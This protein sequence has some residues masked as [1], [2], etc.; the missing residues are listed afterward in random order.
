MKLVTYNTRFGLGKDHR[1]NLPRIVDAVRGADVIALQ[2]IRRNWP[3]NYEDQPGEIGALLPEYYWIYGPTFDVDASQKTNDGNVENRRRQ[4]GTMLL[5]KTPIIS[6]RLHV[7]P[8]LAAVN[9]FNMDLGAVEGVI[10]TPAGPVR[11]YSIH[12][13]ALGSRERVMQ[14][15]HFLEIHR[16]AW[17]EGGAWTGPEN[18][19]EADWSGGEPMPPMS[20][21]AVVMG[22]FNSEKDTPEYELMAGKKDTQLGNIA[23]IDSFVDSWEAAGNG[24]KEL[25]TWVHDS[26]ASGRGKARLDYCF[27]SPSLAGKV[28]NAWLDNEAPGSDHQ[29][30]WVELNF[31]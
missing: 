8:K 14:I 5:S 20:Q 19:G 6:S 28:K 3:P 31:S 16:R 9:H 30:Y 13:S 23:Y 12:L 17:R 24:D 2:E 18:C 27:I 26:M 29:P 10:Q 1:V 15:N 21:E 11:F 25:I 4:F 7:F 22:D